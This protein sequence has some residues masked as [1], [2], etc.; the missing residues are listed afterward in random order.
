MKHKGGAISLHHIVLDL[1]LS[2]CSQFNAANIG[3]SLMLKSFQA[4]GRGG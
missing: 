3:M 1:P 2:P 4:K